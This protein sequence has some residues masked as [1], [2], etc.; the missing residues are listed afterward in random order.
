M[1]KFFENN[2]LVEVLEVIFLG[3]YQAFLMATV[4]DRFQRRL[5]LRLP[6]AALK[7]CK[8]LLSQK[9]NETLALNAAL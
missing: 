3:F 5:R 9:I 8:H 7:Y 4:F 1:F 6:L 2:L